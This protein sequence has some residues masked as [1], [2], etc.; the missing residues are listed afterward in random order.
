MSHY[1]SRRPWREYGLLPASSS[2]AEPL[3]LSPSNSP[4]PDD[5]QFQ[6]KPPAPSMSGSSSYPA[7]RLPKRYTRLLIATLISGVVL[8]SLEFDVLSSSVFSN[9][10]RDD[11]LTISF[12][13]VQ[14]RPPPDDTSGLPPL[15]HAY[16]EYEDSLS[17]KHLVEQNTTTGSEDGHGR[18]IFFANHAHTC[19][20]GNVL[21]EMLF[22]ALLADK[23]GLGYVWDDYTWDPNVIDYS[24]FNGKKITARKPISTLLSGH[25]LGIGSSSDS[26]APRAISSRT[27][28]GVCPLDER[29]YID[30]ETVKE[31]MTSLGYHA[32]IVDEGDGTEVMNA[33]LKVLRTEKYRNARCIEVRRNT[34]HVFD[35]WLFGSSRVH[36][37]WE[38]ISRSPVLT[39][40]GW[41]PLIHRAFL[42][43]VQFFA[44]DDDVRSRTPLPRKLWD[45]LWSSSSTLSAA[46]TSTSSPKI[47]SPSDLPSHITHP[48]AS[49]PIL[50][51]HIRR[52][53]YE[54]HCKNLAEWSASYMGFNSFPQH[55]VRDRFDVPQIVD[56]AVSNSTLAA[57]EEAGTE[58]N[59]PP[60]IDDIR[61]RSYSDPSTVASMDERKEIYARHCYP[62]PQQIVR[63]VRQVVRDYSQA[64]VTPSW[65]TGNDSKRQTGMGL[66][67]IYIMTN[68]DSEWAEEVKRALGQDFPALGFVW[69]GISTSRD[70]ILGWEEKPVVQA[71][72][73]YVASRAELFVG[74]GFSSLTANIVMLRMKMGFDTVQTRFW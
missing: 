68:G 11:D 15:Y 45:L 26:G 49:L 37:L 31:Y 47:P 5:F 57:E 58:N 56:P 44:A 7:C 60:D 62:S 61:R 39:N 54:E 55:R 6:E 40:W 64:Q 36:S 4:S 22:S 20:W 35:M 34:Y 59:V 12:P 24:Y 14:D 19:G 23:A 29:V 63:R 13:S 30:R 69:E 3:F 70:L 1:F 27:Y 32:G 48:F 66:N 51:L 74:N 18:Y 52:G 28:E 33:W 41:S 53:D 73:M 50:V 72:D 46:Y 8:L 2:S 25:V 71:L 21:Q 43:N 65:W 67:K 42:K 9:R 17:E 38:H 10:R 16:R